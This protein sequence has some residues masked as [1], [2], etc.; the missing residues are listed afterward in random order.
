MPWLA[1]LFKFSGVCPRSTRGGRASKPPPPRY[2]VVCGVRSD[3]VGSG[4]RNSYGTKFEEFNY[5]TLSVSVRLYPVTVA[6]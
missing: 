3:T 5:T 4:V 2:F 1:S 6:A